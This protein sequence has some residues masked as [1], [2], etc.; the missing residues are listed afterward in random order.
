MNRLPDDLDRWSRA[1]RL[2]DHLLALGLWVEPVF[3][4][5]QE[6]GIEYLRVSVAALRDQ[7]DQG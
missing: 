2:C 7:H 1:E 3:S 6:G 4:K 5:E